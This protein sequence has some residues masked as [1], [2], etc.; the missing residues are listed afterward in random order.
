MEQT[1]LEL[2]KGHELSKKGAMV[3]PCFSILAGI[4]RFA[5]CKDGLHPF[6]IHHVVFIV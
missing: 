5:F 4:E 2:F 3:E 1:F 6:C